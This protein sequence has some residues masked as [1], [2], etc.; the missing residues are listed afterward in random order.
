MTPSNTPI[1]PQINNIADN[2]GNKHTVI[3]SNHTH[4]QSEVAGLETFMN[5]RSHKIDKSQGNTYAYVDAQSD[6]NTGQAKIVVG[7][8]NSEETEYS[9]TIAI[10]WANIKNLERAL[11]NPDTTPTADSDNFVTSGGVKAA[12]DGKQDALTFDTTPTA[13]S[14]N[15]VTSDGVKKALDAK[16]Q[17]RQDD[18]ET[19]DH[20]IV[21][22]TA[23]DGD[24]YIRFSVREGDNI[25]SASIT[26]D[27]IENLIRALIDPDSTPTADSDNL[28]TSGGV[29]AAIDDATKAVFGSMPYYITAAHEKMHVHTRILRNNT[30]ATIKLTECIDV[31]AL[32]AAE[33]AN[34]YWNTPDIDIPND[35]EIG[36]RFVR[37][38][39]AVFL[40]Y[41]GN[42]DY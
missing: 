40:F 7:V 13:G 18:S 20:A 5:T 38:S 25:K 19:S 15:P 27:N 39:N 28:V 14:T 3:P 8:E 33:R 26:L 36:I 41:D 35:T 24:V 16:R 4:A 32:P 2:Q 31:T 37:A 21:S 34:I 29:K 30:G 10:T 23:E 1:T 6:T 9:R 22:A 11:L 17:I 42:F 12:L